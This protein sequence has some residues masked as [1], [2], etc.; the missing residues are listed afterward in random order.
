MSG[1]KNKESSWNAEVEKLFLYLSRSENLSQYKIDIEEEVKKIF[2]RELYKELQKNL[3][4]M[5]EEG[6]FAKVFEKL[7]FSEEDSSQTNQDSTKQSKDAS[8]LDQMI[9]STLINGFQTSS[10][11]KNLFGI[12]P[13]LIG[14]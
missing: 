1:K 3:N 9:A 2:K 5:V 11:L 6:D 10:V 13:N 7:G 12:V 4:K 14:R 8:D